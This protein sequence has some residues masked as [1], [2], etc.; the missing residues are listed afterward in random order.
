MRRQS[1]RCDDHPGLGDHPR[2]LFGARHALSGEY[3]NNHTISGSDSAT[4]LNVLNSTLPQQGG[5]GGQIV[6]HAKTGTVTAQQSAVSQS[7]ADVSKLPDV[8]K[9]ASPFASANTDAVS[10]DGTIAYAS[11]GWNV[12]PGSF[13]TSCL[14]ML[15]N[16]VARHKAGLRAEHSAFA[17]W[18]R[19][20]SGRPWP[21]AVLSAAVLVV[22]AIPLFSITLGQPVRNAM[23]H[24]AGCAG[25]RPGNPFRQPVCP[26][27]CTKHRG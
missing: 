21:W 15:N 16:A 13:G 8:I 26:D 9:V 24:L 12:T 25:G 18:G 14:D 17:R 5:Y 23:S 1:S 19:M 3:V 20:V 2:G 27:T 4:G 11:V 10:K 7:V 22:L 6:F